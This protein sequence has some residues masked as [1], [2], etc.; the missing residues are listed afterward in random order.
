MF[1][2]NLLLPYSESTLS[3]I[4]VLLGLLR[5]LICRPQV[6]SKAGAH[7]E[8]FLWGGGGGVADPDAIYTTNLCLILKITL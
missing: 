8:P 2:N 3:K 1:R 4:F 7:P 6:P 5:P